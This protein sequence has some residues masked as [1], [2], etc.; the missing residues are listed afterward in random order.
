[1]LGINYTRR[2]QVLAGHVAPGWHFV[3]LAQFR[4]TKV[5]C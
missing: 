2:A 1:M 5:S 4:F 3:A